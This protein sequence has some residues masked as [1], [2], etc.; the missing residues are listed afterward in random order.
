MRILIVLLLLFL[1]SYSAT[2]LF[3][4][5]G[6]KWAKIPRVTFWWALVATLIYGL[7]SLLMHLVF[8]WLGSADVFDA[9]L[10]AWG[11]EF[12]VTLLVTWMTLQTLFRT[13]LWRAIVSWLPTLVPGAVTMA[14][15]FLV[16]PRF[17]L[18]FYIQG[19]HSMA[20][21]LLGPNQQGVCP[22]CGQPATVSFNPQYQTFEEAN[23]LGICSSCQQAGEVT[24]IGS[25]VLPADRFMVDLL[26]TPQ[27]WDLVVFRSL[28]DPS[29]RY[30]KRLVGFPGEEVVIKEGSIWI[31]GVKQEPPSE[32]TKLTFTSAPEGPEERWGS[33]DRPM[34]LGDDEYFVVGDFSLQ[35][36]DSRS[37]GAL[38]GKNIEGV[39]RIVYWPPARWRQI[40]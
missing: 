28:K 37:W 35:S 22:H 17:A 30:V 8:Q 1:G 40:R 7:V 3:L 14:L 32:I 29:V 31:N 39:V 16:L 10:L 21:T 26:S 38:P 25:S 27:R 20:P 23:R 6:A 4:W 36:A 19:N 2:A 12:G 18:A 34:Q 24:H 33:P 13:S 9:P 5:M 15:V 11:F